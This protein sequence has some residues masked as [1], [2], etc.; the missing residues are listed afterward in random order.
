MTRIHPTAIIHDGAELDEHVRVG[1]YAIV[2]P[3]A[4]IG[5]GT[6]IGAHAIVDGNTT[7]GRDNEIFPYAVVGSRPQDKK[8]RGEDVALTIGDRNVIREFVTI[9]PGTGAGGGTTTIGSGNLLMAY[10]H[11][12]HDCQISDHCVFSNSAQLAGHVIVED[13]V[14]VGGMSGIHQFVRLGTGAM[15]GGGSMVS[16]DVPP[17]CL[18]EGNRASLHGLNTIGLRRA[19]IDDAAIAA[20]KDVYRL[21]FRRGKGTKAAV[22]ELEAREDLPAEA[23]TLVR[24][25]AASK[26]GVCRPRR[27]R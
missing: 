24:F 15:I 10:V 22:A 6:S 25:V 2:G 26:R 12:A 3:Q 18:V 9:N 23:R 27:E 1:P 11:V 7:L 19:G 8:F 13:R 16:L 4:K 20:L 21:I 17:F 14:I 5:A